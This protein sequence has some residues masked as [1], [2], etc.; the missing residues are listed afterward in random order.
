M[1][2]RIYLGERTE[3]IV[4]VGNARIRAFGSTTDL[5]DEGDVVQLDFPP[6]AIRAWPATRPAEDHRGE[7]YE[8]KR[9]TLHVGARIARHSDDSHGIPDAG[10]DRIQR[11]VGRRCRRR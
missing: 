10:S 6:E 1:L 5:H 2:S 11:I 3:Y 8:A 7:R 9:R 4:S